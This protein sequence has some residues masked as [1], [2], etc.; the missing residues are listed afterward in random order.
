[1]RWWSRHYYIMQKHHRHLSSL[2]VCPRRS[3]CSI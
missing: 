2:S 1:L 3:D